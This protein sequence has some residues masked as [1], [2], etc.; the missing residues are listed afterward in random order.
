MSDGEANM[1]EP[2]TIRLKSV[3]ASFK[4][5]SRFYDLEGATHHGGAIAYAVFGYAAG[6]AGLFAD[7]LLINGEQPSE[8]R[9]ARLTCLSQ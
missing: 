8:C 4:L 2:V 9:T 5:L 1:S 3:M 7:S 6:L